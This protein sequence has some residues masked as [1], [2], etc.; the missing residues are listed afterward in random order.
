MQKLSTIR[1]R[2][3]DYTWECRAGEQGEY[4]GVPVFYQGCG[5][6][7]PIETRPGRYVRRS[8]ACE[9]AAVEAS[10]IGNA[11]ASWNEKQIQETYGWLGLKW[12]DT[13]LAKKLFANFQAYGLQEAFEMTRAF[14]DILAGTLVLHGPYGTGKTHLLAAL[15]NELRKRG[16]STRFVTA[17]KLFTV[18]QERVSLRESYTPLITKAI[19]APLFVLDDVDKAK[20]TD[21]REEVYFAIIDER[22]KLGLPMAIS[23][24]RLAELKDFVGGACASRLSIGQ[25]SVEMTGEDYR[26]EL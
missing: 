7:H 10:Q 1:L 20:H 19:H 22:V 16:K 18:I 9:R 15:C 13:M 21:F 24:N 6:I 4:R 8:C 12:S 26:K 2:P 5:T 11:T 14:A 25:I 17:P 3:E 23:T